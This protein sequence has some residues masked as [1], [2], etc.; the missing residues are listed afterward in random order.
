VEQESG[1]KESLLVEKLEPFDWRWKCQFQGHT[2]YDL[3]ALMVVVNK[4][5]SAHSTIGYREIQKQF[6]KIWSNEDLL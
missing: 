4:I 3:L 1:W 5:Q 2:E 6:I